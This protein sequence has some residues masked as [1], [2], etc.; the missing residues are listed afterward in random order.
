MVISALTS[1]ISIQNASD[2]LHIKY[3]LRNMNRYKSNKK[4]WFWLILNTIIIF[5]RKIVINVNNVS[6]AIRY[7]KRYT[8]FI[9]YESSG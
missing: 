1:H 9:N 5:N 2:L 7:F 8:V 4:Y 3:L 6:K